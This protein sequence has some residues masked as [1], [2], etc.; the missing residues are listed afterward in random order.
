MSRVLFNELLKKYYKDHA[1]KVNTILEGYIKMNELYDKIE[2]NIENLE[3]ILKA[4]NQRDE[5]PEEMLDFKDSFVEL[6]DSCYNI[7]IRAIEDENKIATE[8]EAED[9]GTESPR[10]NITKD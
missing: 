6:Y 4:Y 1:V 8:Y 10:I 2:N 9:K 3:S 7:F 5:L